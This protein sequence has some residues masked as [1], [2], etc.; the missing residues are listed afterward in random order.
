[1]HADKT[2]LSQIITLLFLVYPGRIKK[3]KITR[4]EIFLLGEPL[5]FPDEINTQ[6]PGYSFCRVFASLKGL[7]FET[8][9]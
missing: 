6:F 3:E 7:L 5:L 2:L 1:L 9:Q 4:L 8:S